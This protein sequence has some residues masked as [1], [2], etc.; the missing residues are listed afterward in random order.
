MPKLNESRPPVQGQQHTYSLDPPTDVGCEVSWFIDG[1]PVGL[2]SKVGGL[3]VKG[4]GAAGTMTVEVTGSYHDTMVTAKIRCPEKPLVTVGPMLVGTHTWNPCE[5]PPCRIPRVRYQQAAAAAT[6]RADGLAF[7]CLQFRHGLLIF[8]ATLGIFIPV[9]LAVLFCQTL[10]L[11]PILCQALYV[12]L[13][14]ATILMLWALS[15]F[16]LRFRIFRERMQACREARAEMQQ[17]YRIMLDTCPK[18]CQ[19][20]EVTVDCRCR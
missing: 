18:E 10:H 13:A 14:A 9:L 19:L 17:L 16:G 4:F 7:F 11:D 15:F 8:L 5:E 2:G 1:Q 12:A 20:A 6:E 3:E